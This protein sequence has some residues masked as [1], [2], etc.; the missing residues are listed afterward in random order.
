M[1]FNL[2]YIVYYNIYFEFQHANWGL[3]KCTSL[4][5]IPFHHSQCVLKTN[6]S[7][8]F[9]LYMTIDVTL[10][11]FGEGEQNH[12]KQYISGV[13]LVNRIRF[14][15]ISRKFRGGGRIGRAETLRGTR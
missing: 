3:P 9:Y 4:Y 15:V 14:C 5:H 10:P 8:L 12:R 6:L 7:F 13:G 1:K 2:L 11:V